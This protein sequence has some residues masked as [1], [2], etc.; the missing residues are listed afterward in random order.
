MTATADSIETRKSSGPTLIE[1]RASQIVKNATNVTLRE[2]D[3]KSLEY[4]QIKESI[5]APKVSET[6][7]TQGNVVRRQTSPHGMLNP[8]SIR[9]CPG[10]PGEYA[11]VDGAHRHT[12]WQE[13]FGD[14]LPIP[15][16]L[17]DLNDLQTMEAQI[18]GNFHVKKT[19]PAEY[20]KQ[21][22]RLLQANPMRTISEQ[23]ARLH[24][25][26]ATLTQWFGLLKLKGTRFVER[27][28][29]ENPGQTKQV[30]IMHV[31][32]DDGSLPL[33]A[34]FVISTASSSVDEQQD[35]WNKKQDELFD[36][37]IVAKTTPQGVQKFC[38]DA[39]VVI[40]EQKKALKEKRDPNAIEVIAPPVPR[41]LG[42]MKIELGRQQ[43][44]VLTDQENEDIQKQIE[45]LA[46]TYPDAVQAISRQAYLNGIEFALQVDT[47]TIAE[48]KRQ[49]E[50]QLKARKEA[51]DEKKGG[52][53]ATA[54]SRSSGMFGRRL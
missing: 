22:K 3:T 44:A 9:P 48:R 33:S 6:H 20:V 40:K 38:A 12:A 35:F 19:K 45:E 52:D 43:E 31:A 34:A 5:G 32:V 36:A 11:L 41:K 1:V 25:E 54:I 42:E 24:M 46:K 51:Q 49:K 4:K 37:A 10:Q 27:P 16:Y 47:E 15:A 18:E 7:D 21:I 53:K 30:S 14:S 50:E 23:A 28:D 13:L 26:P 2:V 8:I 29:P 39:T 17:I